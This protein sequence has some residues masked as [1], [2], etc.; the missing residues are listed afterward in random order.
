MKRKDPKWLA[1]FDG[2]L[3]WKG[4]AFETWERAKERKQEARKRKQA[5]R[6]P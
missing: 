5:R 4:K 1:R 3:A 6:K 2:M